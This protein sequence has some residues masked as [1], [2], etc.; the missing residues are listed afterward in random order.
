LFLFAASCFELR[1]AF[2]KNLAKLFE[3]RFASCG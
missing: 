2:G 1:P 3:S